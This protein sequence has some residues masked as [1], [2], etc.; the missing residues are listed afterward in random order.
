MKPHPRRHKIKS[1]YREGG[2]EKSYEEK[3]TGRKCVLSKRRKSEGSMEE[4]GRREAV[5]RGA[6]ERV[7][8]TMERRR[9]GGSRALR[10]D[11][12]LRTAPHTFSCSFGV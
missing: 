12:S 6:E 10:E 5:L 8:Q 7:S 3:G 1:I 11:V 4:G 2:K 9:T